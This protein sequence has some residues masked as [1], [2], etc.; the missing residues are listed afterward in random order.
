MTVLDHLAASGAAPQSTA[1]ESAE[2]ASRVRIQIGIG[3][4][5]TV[6]IAALGV[7]LVGY[8]YKESREAALIAADDLFARITRQTATNIQKLYAPAEALVDLT[9]TLGDVA[10]PTHG[11]RMRLL[12]YFAESLR[13]APTLSSLYVGYPNGEF[14]Q[15]RAVGDDA[16][17]RRRIKAP[18]GTAFALSTVEPSLEGLQWSW[19]FYDE[20][21]APLATRDAV[22]T[23]YDPRA[24]GWYK[25]AI[26]SPRQVSTD[27]YLFQASG[28]WG[29]TLARRTPDRTAVVGA[30]LTLDTL[31]AAIARER[32]TPSTAVLVI[33]GSGTMIGH[34]GTG[35]GK[36]AELDDP[37]SASVYR[38]VSAGAKPGRLDLSVDGRDWLGSL[39]VLPLRSG[40]KARLAVVVPRDELL[41]GINELRNTSVLLSLGLLAVSF[42]VVWWIARRIARPLRMLAG[43]AQ[44]IRNFKLDTEVS[45]RSRFIEVNE[46]SHSMA[47]MK[48]A[49]ERFVAISK[50]LSAE[51]D[52]DRL[53]ERLLDEAR[54]VCRADGGSIFL[55]E[56][57]KANIE[58][59]VVQNVRSD[60]HYGGTSASSVPDALRSRPVGDRT[61]L[62]DQPEAASVRRGTTLAM[63]DIAADKRCDFSWLRERYERDDYR[64]RS[65]LH[66]PLRNRKGELIG[67]LELVNTRDP[68]TDTVTGF[69]PDMVSYVSAISSQAA[70]TLDNQRLLK[71]QKDLLDAFIQLIAGAID[72]KSAYTGGH[73]QRVPELARMLAQA[74][75]ESQESPF[76]AFALSDEEWYEL[77]LASWLHDCGKV[78]TP[79][80]VVDKA[81]KL[82]CIYNRI[83][84]IRM[85][86]EVLW[87]DA[88]IEHYRELAAGAGD[89]EA[90]RQALDARLRELQEGYAFVAECN[91]GG[92]FMAPERIER[93]QRIAARVWLRHF[94]DRIGLSHEELQRKA[95]TPAA[96]LPA[97]ERLLADKDEHRV[98]RDDGGNPFGDNPYGFRVEVPKY[99]FNYGELYNLSVARGTLTEEERFK[100]NEH[101]IQTIVLL[102]Q[103]PF[104]RELRRVP[105]WAGNHHE[106]LDGTGYPRGLTAED[107][108][109]PERI[110]AIA[111]IFE[112]L[113]AS[114][115]PYKKAKTLSESIRIMS[116]MCRDGHICPDLFA[117]FLRSG[118]Y[119]EYAR[120][121]LAPEQIDDVDVAQYLA[122][123]GQMQAG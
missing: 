25:M 63:D 40:G 18:R 13:T 116:F 47:V 105:T 49:I 27:F 50:A 38:E 26:A 73:C 16:S 24:R 55:Y 92:E 17:L 114:D 12:P 65:L 29:A 23:E 110:M 103:L 9:V 80:N 4:V 48:S 123:A 99:A 37:V 83:H 74:A 53:L 3:I 86:F 52:F 121:F 7:A 51:K 96:S 87:R 120:A 81:T 30:D 14:F 82:E 62:T 90:S 70:I 122:A 57:D 5:F 58:L 35:K 89:S 11:E 97:E 46:L 102:N 106:K 21:L 111:D 8:N 19:I 36:C 68:R 75:Q 6:L 72:A 45:V 118:V 44:R 42:V 54:A 43:A 117:L 33:L 10:S 79:E 104:P 71:A 1:P 85:R 31:C 28:V 91:Q 84:E 94:D 112:A 34:S 107:L 98:P 115:R 113:T 78:T 41:S 39:A 15:L 101:I 60:V 109:R 32:V 108:S 66:L 67:L 2:P 22:P 64:C 61:G 88:Q 100:I 119:L 59:A 93:L 77:H 76:Q 56:P 69:S 95:R 20:N